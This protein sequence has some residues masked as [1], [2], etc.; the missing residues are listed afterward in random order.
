MKTRIVRIGNSRGIR[1]P[2]VLLEQSRLSGEVTVLVKDN[3]LIIEL[4]HQPRAGWTEAF[5]S[6]A[7]HDDDRLLDRDALPRTLWEEEE[8]QWQ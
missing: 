8:W 6:M 4:A 3:T 5:E 2:K 7:E 1:I